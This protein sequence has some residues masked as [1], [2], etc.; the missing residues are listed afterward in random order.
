M[1]TKM[2]KKEKKMVVSYF[3]LRIFY[4][5]I[6]QVSDFFSI[7]WI[8]SVPAKTNRLAPKAL[9]NREMTGDLWETRFGR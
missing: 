7:R 5:F 8:T 4:I 3:K 6:R 1:R 9:G 2:K